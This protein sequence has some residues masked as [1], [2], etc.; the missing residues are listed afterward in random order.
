MISSSAAINAESTSVSIATI[1]S[2]SLSVSIPIAS[3]AS[4]FTNLMSSATTASSRPTKNGASS[5]RLRK[6]QCSSVAS[7]L[8]M[9]PFRDGRSCSRRA[10]EARATATILHGAERPLF[11]GEDLEGAGRS[12]RF[13]GVD[14]QSAVAAHLLGAIQRFVGALNQA[15]EAA[16]AVGLRR[17]GA[18]ADGQDSA[19]VG[20]RMRNAHRHRVAADLL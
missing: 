5:R 16:L 2:L 9:A 13:G 4:C 8:F 12:V 7:T 3:V 10:A 11:D 6:T 20:V 18:D 14:V 1:I 17:R 15:G 19:R